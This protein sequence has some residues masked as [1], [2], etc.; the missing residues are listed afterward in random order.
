LA[1]PRT[2]RFKWNSSNRRPLRVLEAL[3][4]LLLAGETHCCLVWARRGGSQ[5]SSATAHDPFPTAL[6]RGPM[7]ELRRL[8]A[9]VLPHGRIRHICCEMMR[10][11][12]REKDVPTTAMLTKS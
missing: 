5:G 7:R 2:Q 9:E 1:D 10:V 8:M 4:V 3:A 12:R 6:G 11:N